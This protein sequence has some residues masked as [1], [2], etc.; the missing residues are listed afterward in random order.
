M[1]MFKHL[2]LALCFCWLAAFNA[3]GQHKLHITVT[4]LKGKGPVYIA[5]YNRADDFGK[6]HKAYRKLIKPSSDKVLTATAEDLPAGDY[7][8]AIYQDLNEN[9]KIDKNMLGIPTEP[10]GFSN[11]VRP[12]V[13]APTFKQCKVVI[14]KSEKSISIILDTY[15]L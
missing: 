8:V 13:S 5:I 9:K 1:L 14:D 6:P 2:F 11:N 4:N 12:V 15:H 3:S 7:A 10:F